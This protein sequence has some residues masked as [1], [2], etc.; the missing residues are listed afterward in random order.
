MIHQNQHCRNNTTNDIENQYFP[1]K[2]MILIFGVQISAEKRDEN[3]NHRRKSEQ[4]LFEH[5]KY[6]QRSSHQR[7]INLAF[8][9]IFF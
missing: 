7:N 1:E 6:G 4:V 2:T 3:E 8:D 5:E 9:H